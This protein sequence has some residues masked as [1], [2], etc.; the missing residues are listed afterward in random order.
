MENPV[1]DKRLKSLN[2]E[3]TEEK[4]FTEDTE[5]SKIFLG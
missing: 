4:P 5:G 3:D 1:K 2:T